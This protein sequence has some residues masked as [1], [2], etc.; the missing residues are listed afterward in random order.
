MN[1]KE[2]P[3]KGIRRSDLSF[4]EDVYICSRHFGNEKSKSFFNVKY[5]DTGIYFIFPW[6]RNYETILEIR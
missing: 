5:N 3:L 4:L 1:H 2:N 6:V